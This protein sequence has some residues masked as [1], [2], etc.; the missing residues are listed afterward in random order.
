[1][2]IGDRKLVLMID[3]SNGNN[4]GLGITSRTMSNPST[5]Y[6]WHTYR[7]CEN[8]RTGGYITNGNTG[9]DKVKI[10]RPM[11]IP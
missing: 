2:D 7:H 10:V 3:H 9:L 5:F 4:H 6:I 1:M 8:G 11:R